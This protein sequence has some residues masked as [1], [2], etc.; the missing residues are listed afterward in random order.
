M[1]N[2]IIEDERDLQALIVDAIEVPALDIER[3]ADDNTRFE[4]F[5]TWYKKIKDIDTHIA[6]C[7]R[8]IDHL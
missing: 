1:H 8:L 4:Q 7:N 2:M 6:L 3:V 5:R